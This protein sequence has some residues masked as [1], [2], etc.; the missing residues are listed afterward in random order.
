MY[1]PGT[2][3]NIFNGSERERERA[4]VCVCMC[5]CVCV[6]VYLKGLDGNGFAMARGE[7]RR[8]GGRRQAH[9]LESFQGLER[10]ERK[11]RKAGCFRM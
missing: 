1:T 3:R 10:G 4:C 11:K 5:V 9:I 7:R 2:S 8:G 6:C